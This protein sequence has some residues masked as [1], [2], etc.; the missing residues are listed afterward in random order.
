MIFLLSSRF[1]YDINRIAIIFNL[2]RVR[3]VKFIIFVVSCGSLVLFLSCN[4]G[5]VAPIETPD[6]TIQT[7]QTVQPK[8]KVVTSFYPLYELAHSIGAEFTTVT[9]LVPPGSE[10]HEFE[11]TPQDIEQLIESNLVLMNGAGLEP[12]VE[13]LRPDLVEKKVPIV[14]MS[15]YVKV[16]ADG[17]STTYDPHFWLDPNLYAEEAR[18]ITTALKNIDPAHGEMY[19][20][21][22]ELYSQKLTALDQQYQAALKSC[23]YRSFVTNHAAFGYLARRYGL[24]MVA[25]S[26][27]SPE[28]EP[29][30]RKIAELATYVK[31]NGIQYIFSETLMSPKVAQT[32][33]EEVGIQVLV[34]NPLEG[35]TEE[36]LSNGENYITVMQQNLK[37]LTLALECQVP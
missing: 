30:P 27:L 11:P 10:P 3:F 4:Q 37:N 5:A 13:N 29:S 9:N 8:R 36:E 15:A 31:N 6:P 17:A 1:F 14:D 2:H 20:Q 18:I 19:E 25:I 33:A 34:L 7:Q 35:L 22:L 16:S 21:N 12:W 23:K 32:L 28:S 24:E 26:G